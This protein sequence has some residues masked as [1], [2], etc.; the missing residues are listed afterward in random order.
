MTAPSDLDL[1]GDTTRECETCGG[2]GEITVCANDGSHGC[3][4]QFDREYPCPDCIE[5]RR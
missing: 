5:G 1:L 4:H 2:S 3:S